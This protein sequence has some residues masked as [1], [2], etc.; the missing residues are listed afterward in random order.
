LT[1]GK[2]AGESCSASKKEVIRF[3]ISNGQ[4]IFRIFWNKPSVRA[5]PS[6]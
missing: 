6:H 2:E 5:Y 1:T 4:S 3:H